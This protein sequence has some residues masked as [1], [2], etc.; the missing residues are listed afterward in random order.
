MLAVGTPIVVDG[1]LWGASPRVWVR[2]ESPPADTE[3]RMAEFAQLLET[4][5][6][7]AD[8]RDQLT[9]SRARLFA[10]GDEARRRVVRDLHDGAHSG[11]CMRS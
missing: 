4:A 9:A 10:A 2:A 11:S 3:Q 6:A 8:S 7:N 5:I 1:R